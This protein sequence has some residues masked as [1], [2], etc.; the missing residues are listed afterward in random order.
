MAQND[1][2]SWSKCIFAILLIVGLVSC[3]QADYEVLGPGSEPVVGEPFGPNSKT[4]PPSARLEAVNK[5]V[6]VTWAF[7]GSKVS[8]RPSADSLDLDY[9]DKSTCP[10]PGLSKAEYEVTGSPKIAVERTDCTKLDSQERTFDKPGEY[11]VTLKVTSADGE[12]AFASMTLKI[13]AVGTKREDIEG[14]FT[15]HAKPIFAKEAQNIQFTGICELKGRLTIA[16][17]FGDSEK[18]SGLVSEHAYAKRGQYR[19]NATCTNETGKTLQASLTVVIIGTDVPKLPE[20]KV[21]VPSENPDTPPPTKPNCDPTQGPCQDSTKGPVQNSKVP[22]PS[23]TIIWY[24]DP[25]C[26][27]YYHY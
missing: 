22:T 18:G 4:I 27:C 20:V 24:Y 7:V 11:P 2:K 10:N 1:N 3:K 19:V 17:D 6:S 16:W 25:Y 12:T 23:K 5:G 26:G 14:G 13:L 15:V 8:F 21:P 9:I